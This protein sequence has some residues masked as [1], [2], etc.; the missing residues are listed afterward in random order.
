MKTLK[1]AGL[2]EMVKERLGTRFW[3]KL[4]LKCL[5]N[6]H[7]ATSDLELNWGGWAFKNKFGTFSIEMVFKALILAV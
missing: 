2:G 5:L 1:E 3:T 6:I 7:I 4:T